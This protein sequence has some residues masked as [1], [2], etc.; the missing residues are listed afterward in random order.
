MITIK[1]TNF[2]KYNTRKDLKNM[3]WFRLQSNIHTSQTLFDLPAEGKWLWIFILCECARNVSDTITL[4]TRY[5]NSLTGIVDK[6]VLEYIMLMQ[7]C[8][9]LEVLADSRYEPVTNSLRVRTENVLTDIQTDTTNITDITNKQTNTSI[10]DFDSIWNK[11]PNKLGK[12][13]AFRHFKSS[14]QTDQDYQDLNKALDNYI[15]SC[16]GSDPKYIKHGSTWFNNWRDWIDYKAP[17]TKLSLRNQ[18]LEY[19]QKTGGNL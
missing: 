5:V 6:K 3:S 18:A 10:F 19:I 1:V 16:K 15:L 9:L 11:Y 2:D 12:K 4:R 13:E 7:N 17:S 8:Q 14:V